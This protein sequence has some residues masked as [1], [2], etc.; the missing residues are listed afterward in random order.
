M[1]HALD[2]LAGAARSVR[3]LADYLDQHPEALLHGR[4]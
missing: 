2:E 4:R 3:S 1:Q